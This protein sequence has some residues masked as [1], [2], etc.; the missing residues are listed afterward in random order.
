MKVKNCGESDLEFG[1]NS[2]GSSWLAAMC[3]EYVTIDAIEDKNMQSQFLV[4]HKV[5]VSHV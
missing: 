2:R 4:N 1:Q 3:K 5:H